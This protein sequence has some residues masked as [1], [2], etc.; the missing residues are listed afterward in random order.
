MFGQRA[1]I[2]GFLLRER[3][4]RQDR[5]E[6]KCQGRPPIAKASVRWCASTPTQTRAPE[7]PSPVR[8][9]RPQ[10][11]LNEMTNGHSRGQATFSAPFSVLDQISF[12]SARP[13][14][15]RQR[16]RDSDRSTLHEDRYIQDEAHRRDRYS[17]AG[18]SRRRLPLVRPF[19]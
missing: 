12:V 16:R 2:V 4:S 17:R 3:I 6:I 10:F 11:A 15:Y 8:L 14:K 5:S 9:A 7:S 18:V 19:C 13:G 1:G